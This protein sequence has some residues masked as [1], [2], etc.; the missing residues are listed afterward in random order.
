MI[1]ELVP[2][3]FKFEDRVKNYT[4]ASGGV[5]TSTVQDSFF[6]QGKWYALFDGMTDDT[7]KISIDSCSTDGQMTVTAISSKLL[8]KYNHVAIRLT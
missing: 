8:S 5:S 2:T 1:C 7:C 4:L 6:V 3:A